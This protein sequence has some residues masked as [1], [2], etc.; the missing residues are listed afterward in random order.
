MLV[1]WQ[2]R[3]IG[4]AETGG[5]L[6]KTEQRSIHDTKLHWYV[7]EELTERERTVVADVEAVRDAF[8]G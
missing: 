6:E 3:S 5:I 2:W 7:S 1:S 4:G 8:A